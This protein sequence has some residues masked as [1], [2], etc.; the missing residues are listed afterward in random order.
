M[1]F[2]GVERTVDYSDLLALSILPVSY[3][4]SSIPSKFHV[5]RSALYLIAI[6]SMFS[7]TATQYSQ[8]VSYNN[9]YQFQSS[10]KELL[11]RMSQLPAN[12]VHRSFEESDTFD[13]RFDSCTGAAT[14]T[15]TEKEKHGVVT[16]KE[17]DYRCPSE[18]NRREMLEYFEKE[19]INKLSEEPIRKSSQV[20]YIWSSLP[21][22]NGLHPS[23]KATKNKG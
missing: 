4:Y 5:P 13:I 12:D 19:F 16:L 21:S 8:K 1:P 20:L 22:N 2:F 3:V 7:F 14:I 18:A 10:R 6:V 9:E 17:I 15:V 23:P 11:E